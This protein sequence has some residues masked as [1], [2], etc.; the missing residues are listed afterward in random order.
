M[1]KKNDAKKVE[2]EEVDLST[3]KLEDHLP[4]IDEHDIDHIPVP[5]DPLEIHPEDLQIEKLLE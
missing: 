3:I 1:P 4:E 2:V 5:L